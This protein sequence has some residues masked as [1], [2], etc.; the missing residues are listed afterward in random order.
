MLRGFTDSL[1]LP[2]SEQFDCPMCA[3]IV[4]IDFDGEHE[5]LIGTYGQVSV[6]SMASVVEHNNP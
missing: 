5:I 4:D 6:F 2:G 1:P 3:C